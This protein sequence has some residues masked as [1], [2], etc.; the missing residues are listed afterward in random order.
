MVLYIF[1]P[2][3]QMLCYIQ[4]SREIQ[5]CSHIHIHS[6]NFALHCEALF[7]DEKISMSRYPN[8]KSYIKLCMYVCMY[9]CTMM[10]THVEF[11]EAFLSRDVYVWWDPSH[12]HLVV[13]LPGQFLLPS[14][15]H[16]LLK[17]MLQWTRTTLENKLPTILK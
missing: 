3:L 16:T 6:T 1:C 10:L 11:V 15:I 2:I 12:H 4:I 13:L 14:A 9:V 17:W 5:K 7:S 8:F